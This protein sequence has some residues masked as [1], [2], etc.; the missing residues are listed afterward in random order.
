MTTRRREPGAIERLYIEKHPDRDYE[1]TC[2]DLFVVASPFELFPEWVCAGATGIA[3][4][5]EVLTQPLMDDLENEDDVAGV[6]IGYW[7]DGM[8]RVV[9]GEDMMTIPEF[10]IGGKYKRRML[11]AAK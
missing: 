2:N 10:N 4:A 1:V 7:A 6:R 8:V 3:S 11:E 9:Y 5:I